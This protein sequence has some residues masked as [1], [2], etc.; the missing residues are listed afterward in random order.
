MYFYEQ[1]FLIKYLPAIREYIK[2]NKTILS[3]RISKD[4]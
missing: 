1:K 3:E 2:R 4:L